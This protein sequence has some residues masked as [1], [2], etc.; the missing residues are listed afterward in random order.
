MIRIQISAI[1]GLLIIL[2]GV[3][4]QINPRFIAGYDDTLDSPNKADKLKQAVGV[5]S[6]SL[7]C[8]GVAIILG[9]LVCTYISFNTEIYVSSLIAPTVIALIYILIRLRSIGV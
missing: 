9:G 5:I 7:I 8:A 4:V 2:S 1:M 6:K 3:L